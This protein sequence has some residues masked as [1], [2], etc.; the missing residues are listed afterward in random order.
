MVEYITV[1]N[2]SLFTQITV[3]WWRVFDFCG[4]LFK[5]LLIQ[6]LKDECIGVFLIIQF[7]ESLDTVKHVQSDII[8]LY[9]LELIH[10]LDDILQVNHL[11]FQK[12]FESFPKKSI[13]DSVIN[14]FDTS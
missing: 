8:C 4:F 3:S 10:E 2:F 11:R 9:T 7:K 6:T 12:Y 13:L 1:R 5:Y 14:H